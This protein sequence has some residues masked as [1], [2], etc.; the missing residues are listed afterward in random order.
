VLAR[1]AAESEARL[2]Y[3]ALGDLFDFELP[4]LPA[5]Q[6]RALDAALLRA[7]VEGAVADRTMASEPDVIETRLEAP[8]IDP[9]C[10]ELLA[11]PKWGWV[12]EDRRP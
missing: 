9:S 3:A 10:R 11:M 4:D 2:S 6:R 8:P 7:E 1:R 12:C 5:P